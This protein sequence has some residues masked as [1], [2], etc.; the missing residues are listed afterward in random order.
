MQKHKIYEMFETWD[1]DVDVSQDGEVARSRCL[2]KHEI[3]NLKG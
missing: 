2:I 3:L 1:M